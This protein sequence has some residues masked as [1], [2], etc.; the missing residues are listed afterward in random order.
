MELL[1]TQP[2]P[3][4]CHFIPIRSKYLLST[5]FS[6][7][8]NL[9]FSAAKSLTIYQILGNKFPT[10]MESECLWLSLLDPILGH[11]NSVHTLTPYFSNTRFNIIFLISSTNRKWSLPSRVVSNNL[12]SSTA[13]KVS[14]FFPWKVDD[15]FEMFTLLCDWK[16]SKLK[17][18]ESSVP[19]HPGFWTRTETVY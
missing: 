9:C 5:L 4:S 16:I 19:P 7:T 13:K 15:S 3:P 11:F 1:I 17:L 14:D 6:N 10:F 18:P 12:L 8:R 2:S